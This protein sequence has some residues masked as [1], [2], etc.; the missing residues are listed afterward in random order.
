MR[1][2]NFFKIV[3]IVLCSVIG[4]SVLFF[5]V[6]WTGVIKSHQRQGELR[7]ALAEVVEKYGEKGLLEMAGL[8]VDDSAYSED[9]KTLYQKD[10]LLN[11]NVFE[12]CNEAVV[13]IK[14]SIADSVS[15]FLDVNVKNG[16]GSGFFFTQDGYILTNE[17][18]VEDATEITVRLWNSD[19]FPA[20]IIGT[21]EENDLAVL[22]A[23]P[24]YTVPYLEFGDSEELKVGQRVLAIGNPFGFDRSMVSGI[25]SGLSRP[26]RD[27]NGQILLGMIQ[28][29]APINP[30]NSGGPLLNSRGKVIGINTSIYTTSGTN[31]GM[32]FAVASNTANLSAQDII[33][34]G[35]PYR[36]WM[37]IVP[38]QLSSSIVEYA[39]LK[40]SSGILVS[41]VVPGGKAEKAGLKG[42]K[43][44]VQYGSSIIYIG[45]DV[46]TS[47]NGMKVTEYGDLFTALGNTRPGDKVS[48]TVNRDGKET[49]LKVELV[50]R[51]A[52]N[53]GWI[54]R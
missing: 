3:L 31:Q 30:G 45:G 16:V 24:G 22:K 14:T 32:S 5:L 42:G 43:N 41:Q 48:V 25:I 37:D 12:K 36:G 21:D 29:D 28:T 13:Y 35:K 52:E 6:K 18:V 23:E 49:E 39:G 34:F 8:S 7:E 27:E 4:L 33:R 26:I 20:S 2:N 51:T 50:E 15:S 9:G 38:V 54:N 10:E 17:H 11:I 47:V 44:L 53:I 19:E 46:I 1:K 40:V